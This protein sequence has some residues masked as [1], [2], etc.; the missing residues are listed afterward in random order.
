MIKSVACVYRSHL[1]TV[2]Y[3][4]VCFFL[5][6]FQDLSQLQET[7]LTE[8]EAACFLSMYHVSESPLLTL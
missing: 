8:G 7:W 6:L 3:L 2:V 4:L 1:I 5:D